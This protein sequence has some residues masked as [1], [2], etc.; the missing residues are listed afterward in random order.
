MNIIVAARASEAFLARKIFGCAGVVETPL[1]T[2]SDS[3]I[4]GAGIFSDIDNRADKKLNGT[5]TH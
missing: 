2:S 5:R 3:A 1:T 4:V